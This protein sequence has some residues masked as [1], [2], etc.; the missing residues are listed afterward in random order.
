MLNKAK[1]KA[2]AAAGGAAA[3]AGAAKD[4]ALSQE[5]L[6]KVMAETAGQKDKLMVA[7][8]PL[9]DQCS[10]ELRDF[11]MNPTV[12]KMKAHPEWLL[13]AFSLLAACKHPVSFLFK[14][15][16]FG[17]TA[18]TVLTG[19]LTGAPAS[20]PPAPGQ[21]AP[22][23]GQ[24]GGNTGLTR[25]VLAQAPVALGGKLTEGLAK[26]MGLPPQCVGFAVNNVSPADA[27]KLLQTAQPLMKAYK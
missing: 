22:M 24:P 8:K 12:E 18:K 7:L 23:A 15:L 20:A 17:G 25:V 16:A 1:E 27:M 19:M 9:L 5:V 11:V 3:V 21:P 26:Q 10:P 13:G 14:S 4:K 6:D 2:A